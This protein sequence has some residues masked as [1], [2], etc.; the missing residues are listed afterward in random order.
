[1]PAY[2]VRHL[3]WQDIKKTRKLQAKIVPLLGASHIKTVRHVQVPNRIS[4]ADEFLEEMEEEGGVKTRGKSLFRRH[5]KKKIGASPKK[6][7]D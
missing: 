1:M 3:E 4:E 5:Q 6:M 2:G 7:A